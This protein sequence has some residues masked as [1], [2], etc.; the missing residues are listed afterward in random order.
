M[1][2]SNI[3]G[4]GTENQQI[5]SDIEGP[6]MD[7][8]FDSEG[9]EDKDREENNYNIFVNFL[10]LFGHIN[11]DIYIRAINSRAQNS[12]PISTIYM[13]HLTFGM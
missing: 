3:E 1:P 13:E 10:F 11:W 8:A 9:S 4:Q 6:D 7:S 12:P 2:N 5:M